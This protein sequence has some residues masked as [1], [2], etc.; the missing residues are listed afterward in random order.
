[1]QDNNACKLGK[2]DYEKAKV[3]NNIFASVFDSNFSSHDSW[4]D[5]QQDGDLQSKVLPTLSSGSWAPDE[6]EHT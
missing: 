5:G 4:V 1:M 3:F 2:T 6:P